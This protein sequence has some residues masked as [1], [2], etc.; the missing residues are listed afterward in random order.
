MHHHRCHEIYY[1]LKGE[2]EY[3]IEDRFFRLDEGDMVLI[4][5]GLLHRTAGKS[6]SRYL[7]SFSDAFLQ[8]F[9]TRA[10]LDPLLGEPPF[11]FRADENERGRINMIFSLLLAEQTRAAREQTPC[12][13][14]LVAGYLYQLLFTMKH[15]TNTYIPY[16]YSDG[17]VAQVVKFIN[18]NYNQIGDIGEIADHFFISK[19]HLCR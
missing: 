4:R 13:E 6:I 8:R 3:F 18:E 15:A 16:D 1:S 7:I 17:R 9:Y 5:K 10:A 14:E 12:N 2:R 19:Y 11:I